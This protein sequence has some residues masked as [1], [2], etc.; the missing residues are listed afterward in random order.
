MATSV[1]HLPD[2]F[3]IDEKAS[4]GLIRQMA[5][6]GSTIE[7]NVATYKARSVE[8][9]LLIPVEDS[10]RKIL[11][12]PKRPAQV[13]SGY[14][15]VLVATGRL[16]STKSESLD[17]TTAQWIQHPE[18]YTDYPRGMSARV[19][20]VSESW[21]DAL[22]YKQED[23]T[24][25]SPGL[26]GPQI[27]ALHLVQGHWTVSSETGT[28]VMPT[29]TG[30]TDTMIGVMVSTPCPRVIVIVPSDA[31]RTQTAEKFMRLG[32]LRHLDG[33]LAHTAKFP[34]VGIL[35][36]RPTRKL[37]LDGFFERCN[38]VITTSQIAG[39]CTDAIQARMAHFCDYLF[40]DEAH[41]VEAPTW[42]AFTA[43]FRDARILQFTATP[44]REDGN[45]LPGKIIYKYPLA[46]AQQDGYFTKITFDPVE[47]FDTRRV[48]EAIA[49]RA[50]E[51]LR[52]DTTGERIVMARVGSVP[53][54]DAVV[55]IYKKY[56]E[57]KPVALHTGIKSASSRQAIRSQIING[58]SRIVVCVDMLGEGFDLPALKIAAFHDV[59]KSLAVTLQLAGRFTRASKHLG[60]AVFIANV[61]DI[62]VREELQKLYQR[63]PDWNQLLPELSDAA[64]D[65]E[66]SLKDFV[67]GFANF[68][69]DIPLNKIRAATSTVVY[70]TQCSDW[71]PRSFG[72]GI[73]RFKSCE[74]V[75]SGVNHERKVLVVVTARKE[76]V[77]WINNDLLYDWVWEL[78][79]IH[80]DRAQKLLFINSSSNEGVYKLLAQ[81]VGGQD[82]QLIN[83]YSVF[84]A[85]DGVK[86]LSLQNI[87]LTEQLG[88]NIRYTG[89]MGPD[90]AS[91]LS[92]AQK[93]NTKQT[94]LSGKG[95]ERG[96]KITV[97]ASRKGRIWSMRRTTLDGLITWCQQLGGK[98]LDESIDPTEVLKGTLESQLVDK[99][100]AE[101]PIAADW[102][103]DI[104]LQ[105]ERLVSFTIDGVLEIG[106]WQCELDVTENQPSNSEVQFHLV[107]EGGSI[108][109]KLE[110][111]SAEGIRDYR[112]SIEAGRTATLKA[113][114]SEIQLE[115]YFYEHPPIVWL[116]NGASLEG[117]S[118]TPLKAL[119]APYPRGQIVDWDWTGIDLRKESQGDDKQADAI[120][121]RV[122]REL[123][124]QKFDFII[125]DDG[126]GEAAD[127]VAVRV[128]GK[129]VK[130]TIDVEFYHC[131]YALGAPGARVDDLYV[132][133]G[134][135]QKSIQW[136][137]NDIKKVDLFTHLLRRDS[138]R[139]SKGR[140]TGIE[141]GSVEKLR[142]I[143]EMSRVSEVR[144]AVYVVQPGLSKARA[145]NQQLELISVTENY[146]KETYQ[147][148][149]GVV[150]SA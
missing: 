25:N 2:T 24:T 128:S 70:R 1:V 49:E 146:L 69:S 84:R 18:R 111:F 35:K 45:S 20:A 88:R 133:C 67:A 101:P 5:M 113:G 112:F 8:G 118:Y 116:S 55:E 91:G 127:V 125:D 80:W 10:D 83:E 16:P 105:P 39:Q 59:R 63:D 7:A 85:F 73:P 53:K 139:V 15:R 102:P 98:L 42:Q 87:G 145:S 13:I 60:D 21:R 147:L 78:F 54:A 82:V 115:T 31:L 106:V 3:A 68:P 141:L 132:V 26:R 92:E 12:L 99:R 37:D 44:F 71:A 97:G 121:N 150:A 72:A 11:V 100:P 114:S 33:V 104:Y 27:G 23:P 41:H 126:K 123:K 52:A 30:K 109:I 107:Y 57:F 93:Q 61:A 138:L 51:H 76:R 110:L 120:Q 64:I 149:F 4:V 6:L 77:D 47:E 48:D 34:I 75:H 108:G 124:K 103:E 56:P 43:H 134:Q 95:F 137:A 28:I 32:V 89:R 148:R 81:A 19:A 119:Y 9:R 142:E 40:V 66:I 17:L 50:I 22:K 38:V 130:R 74:R 90:V 129:G 144:V 140:P 94:V 46:K 65:Y 29:G 58:K 62:N 122:I 143:R 136:V 131:K 86:R 117:N 135:A 96:S 79:V 36:K 14:A